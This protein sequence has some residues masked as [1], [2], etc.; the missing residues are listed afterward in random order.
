MNENYGINSDSMLDAANSAGKVSTQLTDAGS[1]MQTDFSKTSKLNGQS[2]GEISKQLSVLGS[3]TS[4]WQNIITTNVNKG[5][6][7]D[8]R[9]S[10]VA[11]DIEVPL[12]YTTNNSMDTNKYNAVFIAKMDGRSIGEGE[13]ADKAEDLDESTVAAESLFDMTED[14]TK[15]QDYDDSTTITGQSVLG[16]I[17]G[18]AT[19]EK[20][21]D[22]STSVG[23]KKLK[24]ISGDATQEKEYDDDSI[25][26]NKT[27]TDI[28][29]DG[30]EQNE[31]DDNLNMLKQNLSD[32]SGDATT[33][34]EYDD[35]TTI[36]GQSVLGSMNSNGKDIDEDSIIASVLGDDLYE[37]K[38]RLASYDGSETKSEM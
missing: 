16:N 10:E 28:S 19:Q 12:D 14:K 23:N 31:L 21:Y 7:Y 38:D 1:S 36:T 27:L 15:Q 17:S 22:D 18:D 20:E 6:E 3:S 4:S 8:S 5:L 37:K 32:V 24:D 13:D 11:E 29:G 33:E 26:K 35:S 9:M 34:Q 2:V 25:V 30:T